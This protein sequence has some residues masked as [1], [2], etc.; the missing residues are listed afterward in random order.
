MHGEDEGFEG[1]A[2]VFHAM[3]PHSAVQDD[4]NHY[5]GSVGF[6]IPTGTDISE[7]CETRFYLECS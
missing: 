1:C 2:L 4:E 5:M 3:P 7:T 6:T